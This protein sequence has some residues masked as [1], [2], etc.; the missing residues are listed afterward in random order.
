[1]ISVEKCRS[2]ALKYRQNAQ[3]TADPDA[4]LGW[5]ELSDAWLALADEIVQRDS[6]ERHQSAVAARRPVE[7]A[8]PHRIA[9]LK[10]ADLL[11]QRLALPTWP[12]N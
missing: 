1:M 3:L 6:L 8:Q 10:I 7:T 4:S 9:T 12:E 11:R 2:N 5:L